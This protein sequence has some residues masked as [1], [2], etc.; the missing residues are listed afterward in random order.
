MSSV[1]PVAAP[2]VSDEENH[3][4]MSPAR[5]GSNSDMGATC[6]DFLHFHNLVC[7]GGKSCVY[8][9]HPQMTLTLLAK[10]P[11]PKKLYAGAGASGREWNPPSP[12]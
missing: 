10:E 4:A 5:E 2:L 8:C 7:G 11:C 9:Q 6:L 3:L 12:D 1:V